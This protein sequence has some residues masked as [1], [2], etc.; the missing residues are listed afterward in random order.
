MKGSTNEQM[1]N[2][3]QST[4][5]TRSSLQAHTRHILGIRVYAYADAELYLRE[6]KRV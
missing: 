3:Q 2:N 4:I 1:I 5:I 6:K